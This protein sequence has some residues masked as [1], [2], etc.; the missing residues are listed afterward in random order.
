[1]SKPRITWTLRIRSYP[2]RAFVSVWLVRATGADRHGTLWG[3]VLPRLAEEIVAALGLPVERDEC[4]ANLPP[5]TPRECV[6]LV[7][8]GQLFSEDAAP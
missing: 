4:P 8:Q 3:E 1:M 2:D 6:P 5:L 7:D